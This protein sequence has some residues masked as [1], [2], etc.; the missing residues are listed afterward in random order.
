[1][2]SQGGDRYQDHPVAY[3]SRELL[4]R[5]YSTIEK[6]CLAMLLGIKAF[7]IYLIGYPF[8]LQ[9]DSHALKWLQQFKDKNMRLT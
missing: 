5:H 1:M 6:E 3:Y 9:T 2:L 7:E 8:I 4:D